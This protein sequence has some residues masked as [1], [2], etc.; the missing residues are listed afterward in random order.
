M[1]TDDKSAYFENGKFKKG[2]PGFNKPL[3][4]PPTIDPLDAD[5]DFDAAI[6]AAA[7]RF[8]HGSKAKT[9]LAGYCASLRDTRPQDFA[10]LVTKA[11]SRRTLASQSSIAAIPITVD[12]VPCPSNHF[13]PAAEAQAHWSAKITGRPQLFIDNP[14]D[15]PPDNAA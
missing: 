13:V 11:L 2:H 14:P 7:Q 4:P 5:T 8:G 9:G 12:I 1:T 10:V 15:G 3:N 6:L